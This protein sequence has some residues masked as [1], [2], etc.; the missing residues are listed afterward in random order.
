MTSFCLLLIGA[1]VSFI[2][3]RLCKDAKVYMHLLC[4]LLLGFVIGSGVKGA[5]ANASKAPSQE[6]FVTT[7]S[8]PTLPTLSSAVVKTEAIEQEVAS[9]DLLE[10]DTVVSNTENIYNTPRNTEIEDDS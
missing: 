8:S 6:L 1:I 2:A 3:A 4:M 7:A 10:G 5:V 9:Q